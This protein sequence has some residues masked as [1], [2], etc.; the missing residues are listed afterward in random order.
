[1]QRRPSTLRQSPVPALNAGAPALKS[2]GLRRR[3]GRSAGA[4]GHA[5]TEQLLVEV[6]EKDGPQTAGVDLEPRLQFEHRSP[7]TCCDAAILPSNGGPA[8]QRCRPARPNHRLEHVTRAD[9]VQGDIVEVHA[10]NSTVDHL[11]QPDRIVLDLDPGEGVPWAQV[12]AAARQLRDLLSSLGLR[13]WPKL[14]GGKGLHVVVPFEPEHGWDATYL[15]AHRIAQA[16][17]ERNPSTFTLDF[18]KQKR[19]RRILIDYKRNH[20]GAVAVAAYSTRAR[21][22]GPVGIPVS[23][24]AL[25]SVRGS[26][27]WT[28]VNLRQRLERLQHDPWRDFWNCRQRLT[29]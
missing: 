20:R 5:S 13:C 26:D 15:L 25:G 3:S 27:H 1:M 18:S 16:A 14:T 17:L 7:R 21:P 2:A 9:R 4:L 22:N 24:R 28:V 10:W 23:W 11:E 29:R 6:V 19:A 8:V 12:V